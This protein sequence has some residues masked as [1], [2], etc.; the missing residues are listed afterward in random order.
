MIRTYENFNAVK[1]D[2]RLLYSDPGVHMA[3]C[4]YRRPSEDEFFMPRAAI[5]HVQ[6]G[7]KVVYLN[8]VK[9]EMKAGDTLYI[10]RYSLVYSDIPVRKAAF[11]AVNVLLEESPALLGEWDDGAFV[12]GNGHAAGREDAADIL[13][14]MACSISEQLELQHYAQ[15]AHMSLSTFKR[16]FRREVGHSPGQWMIG[17]RLER[18]QFLL[19]EKGYR[20]AQAAQ[21]CGFGDVSYFIRQYRKRF[22]QTPGAVPN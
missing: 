3:L 8:G 17:R 14:L 16:W 13:G 10:P 1:A 11:S 21:E 9:H 7:E 4:R 20:V 2:V 22:G 6:E 18:A 19:R 15:S 12:R 5:T